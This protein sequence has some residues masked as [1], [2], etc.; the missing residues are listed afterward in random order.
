MNH[1]IVQEEQS[2][3]QGSNIPNQNVQIH[4][5]LTRVHQA[6]NPGAISSH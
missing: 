2:P 6:P 5:L 3:R 4:L 1:P